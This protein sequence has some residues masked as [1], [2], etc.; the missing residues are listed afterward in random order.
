ME[1]YVASKSGIWESLCKFW[2][3]I[4]IVVMSIKQIIKLYVKTYSNVCSLKL[5]KMMQNENKSVSE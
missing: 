5:Q 2:K 4:H 3:D 1:Y